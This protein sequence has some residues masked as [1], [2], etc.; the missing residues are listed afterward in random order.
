M[1]NSINLAPTLETAVT[2]KANVILDE[3]WGSNIRIGSTD[4]IYNAK[5]WNA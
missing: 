5:T 3:V 2:E 4:Q 1:V